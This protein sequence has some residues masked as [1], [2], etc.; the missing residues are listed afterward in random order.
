LHASQQRAC[1][2]L[3]ECTSPEYE[4][5]TAKVPDVPVLESLV[6]DN[7]DKVLKIPAAAA[8]LWGTQEQ[9]C[10]EFAKQASSWRHRVV[11]SFNELELSRFWGHSDEFVFSGKTVWIWQLRSKLAPRP[12]PHVRQSVQ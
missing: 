6:Y 2:A 3:L 4:E 12:P 10:S 7:A 11:G 9:E 1:G 5:K 8:K